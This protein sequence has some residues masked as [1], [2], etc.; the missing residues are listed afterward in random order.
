[1]KKAIA[2]VVIIGVLVSLG[3]F[4]FSPNDSV[5]PVVEKPKPTITYNNSSAD[6][7]V[8]DL[9]FPGA[10]TGKEFSV[11]GEARGNWFFEASFPVELLDGNGNVL[12]QA[13]ADAQGDWM[14]TAFVP[15]KADIKIP[16]SYTGLA[17]LVLRKDNPSGLPEHEASISFPFTIEY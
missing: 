11:V 1:M 5:A 3:W 16:T 9:P 10:V 13:H 12:V 6:L 14:T 7:I 15:F 4:G 17:T 2:I 8:V